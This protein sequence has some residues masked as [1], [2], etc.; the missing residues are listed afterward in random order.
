MKS[1]RIFLFFV[2]LQF[3]IFVVSC[4]KAEEPKSQ[5]NSPYT[6]PEVEKQLPP[7]I[8]PFEP[9]GVGLRELSTI[10]R[11]ETCYSNTTLFLACVKGIKQAASKFNLYFG[12][13][14][15]IERFGQTPQKEGIRFGSFVMVE[16]ASVK[17]SPAQSTREIYDRYVYVEKKYSDAVTELY[18]KFDLS[19]E[20]VIQKLSSMYNERYGKIYEG[21][22]FRD[23]ANSYLAS[24]DFVAHLELVAQKEKSQKSKTVNTLPFEWAYARGA[25][26]YKFLSYNDP[27]Q[28]FFQGDR[29]LAINNTKISDIGLE[30]IGSVDMSKQAVFTV[31]D[32]HGKIRTVDIRKQPSSLSVPEQRVLEYKKIA[33]LDYRLIKI[34]TFY[35]EGICTDLANQIASDQSERVSGYIVDLRGND[36]GWVHE[37]TC[38]S[39]LF[40]GGSKLVMKQVPFY[41]P[42]YPEP[43]RFL[44]KV[45]NF[46]NEYT[47][48]RVY[49]KNILPRMRLNDPKTLPLVVL[50]NGESASASEIFAGAIREYKR[51][52][53]VGQKTYGKGSVNSYSSLTQNIIFWKTT[54][55]FFM[56]SGLSHNH[57]AY[58]PDL[59]VPW[60]ENAL[61]E[62]DFI[63]NYE[64][65]VSNKTQAFNP[66]IGPTDTALIDRVKKCMNYGWIHEM[67]QKNFGTREQAD[68]QLYHAIEAVRCLGKTAAN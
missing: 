9:S 62:E 3:S 35:S 67:Q 23:L 43:N 46:L 14:Q 15:N 63:A 19:F 1:P 34:R 54:H 48:S 20:S 28:L 16:T 24:L 11:S 4:R 33:G 21:P 32:A 68:Y 18:P 45:I 49:T 53:L 47:T 31:E 17:N 41:S 56:P 26:V 57:A 27:K 2:V 29:V 30:R 13:A 5:G 61:P 44:D 39:G 64:Y 25:F 65:S 52:L 51:G 38:I 6:L 10:F 66:P 50:V 36:G 22:L 58:I 12:P 59:V 42:L 40:L 60:R 37:A 55:V 7:K 8:I